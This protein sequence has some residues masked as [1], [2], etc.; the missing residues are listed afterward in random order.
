METLMFCT[1]IFR[2]ASERA[3]IVWLSAMLFGCRNARS[4]QHKETKVSAPGSNRKP[5]H[6]THFMDK[7]Y[8]AMRSDAHR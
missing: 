7:N 1:W 8:S 6:D 5:R 4:V 2:Q 3:G